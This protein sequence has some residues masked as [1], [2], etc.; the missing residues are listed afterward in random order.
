MVSKELLGSLSE[1][2]RKACAV[3]EDKDSFTTNDLREAMGV[4]KP[5][6]HAIIKAAIEAG[7][8]TPST[9]IRRA[10]DGRNLRIS[11]YKISSAKS[12]GLCEKKKK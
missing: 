2:F 12:G 7:K 9:T 4:C 1:I 6:A 5:R 8:L 10:I 11:C 3:S